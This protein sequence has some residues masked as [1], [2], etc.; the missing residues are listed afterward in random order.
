MC[1]IILIKV[2]HKIIEN[3]ILDLSDEKFRDKFFAGVLN[4]HEDEIYSIS[5]DTFNGEYYGARRNKNGDIEIMRNNASTGGNSWYY[6]VNEDMTI[7]GI[8]VQACQF[9]PRIRVW[10]KVAVEAGIPTFSLIYK[11]FVMDNLTISAALTIYNNDK[12]LQGVIGTHMLLTD[13]GAFLKDTV[14]K[15]NG[16][17][18]IIEKGS[19]NLIANS[20]YCIMNLV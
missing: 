13:I 10:Y 17:A 9:D 11:H 18:V 8:V 12:K 1:L 19:N 5:Y 3:G 16:Y 4:S 15:Y 14:S 2:N 20:M 6:S 7:G